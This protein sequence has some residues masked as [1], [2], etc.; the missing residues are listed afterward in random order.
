LLYR[1]YNQKNW[2]PQFIPYAKVRKRIET[3]FLQF[4]GYSG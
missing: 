2:K 4:L 3:I 1:R